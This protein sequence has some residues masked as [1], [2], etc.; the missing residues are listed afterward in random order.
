M[1][2]DV[3]L[4]LEGTYPYV[5]GGVSTWVAQLLEHMPQVRFSLLYLG[6]RRDQPRTAKYRIPPNV[7]E[8]KEVFIHDLPALGR[9]QPGRPPYT[10]AEWETIRQFD[11]AVAAGQPLDLGAVAPLFRRPRAA[12]DLLAWLDRSVPAWDLLVR[13]YEELA[14]AG[15]SFLDFFWTHRYIQLPLANLLRAELP[16]ATVYHAACTGYAGLLGAMAARV[17]GAALILTEHG[18]YTRERR[19][20]IFNADWILDSPY[21]AFLDVRRM[22]SYFKDWWTHFFLALSR[23]AYLAATRITTLFEANRAIQERDGAPAERTSIIPNGI[24]T[25]PY[26]KL[27]PRLRHAGDPLEIGFVGRVTA[28]KDVK[29]LLRALA[30]LAA[31]QVPFNAHLIGP[32]DEE[33]EY[34]AECR[35]MARALGLDERVHFVGRADVLTFYPRLDVVV[36]TSISEGQPF[37]ILEANCAGLPVVATDVGACPDMLLGGTAADRD[38]GPSGLTT[39]VAA[40]EETAQA[41]EQLARD[42]ELAHRMGRAGRRR[43]KEHYDIRNVMIAY[44]ALY[45]DHLYARR[46]TAAGVGQYQALLAGVGGG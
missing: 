46:G 23:T 17:G 16:R 32:L 45:E 7:V 19:I 12:A 3:C 33:E 5:A 20:E 11:L 31:R 29:T 26:A 44:Q 42:P 15:A 39:S 14:P 6:P 43:V 28:I 36:L 18:I 25:A 8:L 40:P 35:D 4:I 30:I 13:Q 34:A 21:E 22:E 38:L 24:D 41:L 27:T 1:K 2:S 37:V 9:R 10:A